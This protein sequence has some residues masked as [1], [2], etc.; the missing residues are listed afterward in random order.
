MVDENEIRIVVTLDADGAITGA[1]ALEDVLDDVGSTASNAA[2]GFS[3]LQ[4]SIVTLNQ[5]W[6]LAS[7]GVRLLRSGFDALSDSLDRARVVDGVAQGFE[8][9]QGGAISAELQLTSLQEATSGLVSSFDLMQQANQAVLLGLPT[10]GFDELAEAAIRLGQATGRTATE[11]LSDLVTGVGRASPLIL[12]NLGVVVKAAEAQDK[13]AASINK[14]VEELTEQEKKLAFQEAAFDAIT[15]KASQLA[16]VQDNAGNAAQRLAATF[17]NLT[18]QFVTA[19]NENDDLRNGINL[20][21][22]A[23]SQVPVQELAQGFADLTSTIAN[24]LSTGLPQLQ[25]EFRNIRLGFAVLVDAFQ[26]PFASFEESID[27]VVGAEIGQKLANDAAI[28]ERGINDLAKSLSSLGKAGKITEKEFKSATKVLDAFEKEIKETSKTGDKFNVFLGVMR[29]RLITLEEQGFKPVKEAIEDFGRAGNKAATELEDA[30]ASLKDQIDEITGEDG[31]PRLSDELLT[32]VALFKDGEIGAQEFEERLLSVANTAGLD[33]KE[34][35]AKLSTELSDQVKRYDELGDAAEKA[36]DRAIEA[37]KKQ[38]EAFEA[39]V[40]EIGL[41]LSSIISVVSGGGGR[42]GDITGAIGGI[43]DIAGFGGIGGIAVGGAGLGDIGRSSEDS[44][45]ALSK[46]GG[47]LLGEAL[48]GAIGVE[49]GAAVAAAAGASAAGTVA[50]AQAGGALLGPVGAVVGLALGAVFGSKIAKFFEEDAGKL[51]R[52]G[53]ATFFEKAFKEEELALILG[54]QL[55]EIKNLVVTDNDFQSFFPDLIQELNEGSEE[56]ATQFAGFSGISQ[57]LTQ[58]FGV[59][60]FVGPEQIGAILGQ[61][62]ENLNNLQIALQTAGITSADLGEAL[63]GAFLTGDISANEFLTSLQQANNVLAQ[64]IP[65][66]LGLTRTA[67]DN[68]IK[69]AGVGRIALDALGDLGVEAIEGGISSLDELRQSLLDSG[70]DADKVA[71]LFDAIAAA[72]I[73]SLQQLRDVSLDVA[74]QITAPLENFP[75]FFDKSVEQLEEIEKRLNAIEDKEVTVRI[76][77]ESNF[78]DSG[79]R[80]AL[81]LATGGGTDVVTGAGTE[82]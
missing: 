58:F 13:Y 15:E 7:R 64:G 21:S 40:F 55:R 4:A 65:D 12:D 48:I 49:V 30:F 69:S 63:R 81:D 79:A 47:G 24:L 18:D 28:G 72:G 61:N 71:A 37:A 56:A 67:F 43:L 46:L 38:A 66:G 50:G 31:L 59:G 45:A 23:L 57:A 16:D 60:D 62:L 26:N 17:E 25:N 5:A 22:E 52:Q 32:L 53:V 27:R 75:E 20:L 11:A 2:P 29:K 77:V 9:L 39:S 68:L 80:E 1:R 73:T 6:E 35:L 44:V 51:A 14:T 76:N 8:R 3:R 70:A 82:A 34:E 78:V 41:N 10:E 42:G 33:T 19:L 54:G 36:A 74:A